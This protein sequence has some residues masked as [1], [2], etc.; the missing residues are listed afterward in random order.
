[1][2][3]WCGTKREGGDDYFIL[4]FSFKPRPGLQHFLILLLAAV[5]T[6]LGLLCILTR[7]DIEADSVAPSPLGVSNIGDAPSQ[8]DVSSMGDDGISTYAETVATLMWQMQGP[9]RS[10]NLFNASVP[11]D[12]A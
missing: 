11:G 6:F 12:Q 8:W 5:H 7:V 3:L 1:M 10:D 2:Y 4:G 9:F